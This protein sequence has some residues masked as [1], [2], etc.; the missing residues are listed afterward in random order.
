MTNSAMLDYY[1]QQSCFSQSDKL[2]SLYQSL[3]DDLASLCQIVRGL[4]MHYRSDAITPALSKRIEEVNARYV[5]RILDNI[6][7]LDDSDLSITRPLEKRILGCCRDASLLLCS[8]LRHKGIPAR[9]RVG[10]ATYIPPAPSFSYTD[11]V[12]TEYWNA[13]NQR[14]QLV[15]AEQDA[16]LIERNQIDFDVYDIPRDK[17]ITGGQAWQIGRSDD[18]WND[19]GINDF[20][21]GQW[22]VATYVI[23]DLAALNLSEMLLWDFWGI[24]H[25][26]DSLSADDLSAFDEIAKLT[27]ALDIDYDAIKKLYNT[28]SRFTVSESVKVYS[29]VS[30]GYDEQIQCD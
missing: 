28:D 10:Y 22:F 23:Y 21:K 14:W 26:L 7:A 30:E 8:M 12:V 15:D 13:D 6:I 20:V 16:A 9:I 27:T 25:K 1:C 4:Y 2:D 18:A 17:F 24:M 11:H 3:P 29:P 19:F 5:D